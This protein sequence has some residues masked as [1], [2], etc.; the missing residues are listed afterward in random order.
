MSEKNTSNYSLENSQKW[1]GLIG[2]LI[3]TIASI[4][5]AIQAYHGKEKTEALAGQLNL[6][7]TN[8]KI[9]QTVAIHDSEKRMSATS[10]REFDIKIY[11]FVKDVLAIPLGTPNR[12][13]Q[14][15]AAI[16][17]ANSIASN[18]LR[19]NLIR[20]IE[21]NADN[22][23]VKSETE[24]QV[25]Y[26]NEVAT[27]IVE[28]KSEKTSSS[29]SSIIANTNIDFFYCEVKNNLEGTKLMDKTKSA[30]KIIA[31]SSSH[32][33]LRVRQLPLL[34]QARPGYAITEDVIRFNSKEDEKN[35]A[36]EVQKLLEN[37]KLSTKS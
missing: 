9:A 34:Q 21:L 12:K 31:E 7:E 35:I 19:D 8:L 29:K 33:R 3:S 11:L 6:A 25:R 26:F 17:L 5:G 18:S 15:V 13:N 36:T 28:I 16:A 22:L 20:A 2:L 4:F 23:L 37:K 27:N 30:N 24:K 32:G 1:L 10:D 14:E